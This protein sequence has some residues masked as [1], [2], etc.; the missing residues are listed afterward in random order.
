V[1]VALGQTPL[2]KGSNTPVV[3][4]L[5]E[6]RV[7]A[8]DRSVPAG[9]RHADV[10]TERVDRVD[11]HLLAPQPLAAIVLEA[12]P[13]GTSS[14]LIGRPQCPGPLLH[15]QRTGRSDMGHLPSD[16]SVLRP[17]SNCAGGRDG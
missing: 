15:L 5:A 1:D 3:V 4:E 12:A 14:A 7:L 6:D 17:L 10:V 13:V 2:K 11:A 9:R 8:V 16:I